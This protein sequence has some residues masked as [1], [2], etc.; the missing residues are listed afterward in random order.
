MLFLSFK[1]LVIFEYQSRSWM[2]SLVAVYR[3][4]GPILFLLCKPVSCF[5]NRPPELESWWWTLYVERGQLSCHM[6]RPWTGFLGK[7][8]CDGKA[9]A[10]SPQGMLLGDTAGRKWAWL[11]EA[12]IEVNSQQV[13]NGTSADPT[14]SCRASMALKRCPNLKRRKRNL[15]IWSQS[16]ATDCP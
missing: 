15:Y 1:S 14:G 4:L 10:D 2:E 12:E 5:P 3:W 13:A 9:R 16:L 6:A 8:L 11:H 7:R